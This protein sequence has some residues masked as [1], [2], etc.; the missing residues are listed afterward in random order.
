MVGEEMTGAIGHGLVALVGIGVG[1]EEDELRWMADKIVGLRI[2]DDADGRFDQSLRDVGGALLS[3]SQFTLLADVRKG[4]RPSFTRAAHPDVALPAWE[5][6]NEL[7]RAQ[8][9]EVATG[10]FAVHMSVNIMNDGPV[11]VT[12]DRSPT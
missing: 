1:D 7:V 9:V 8:G 10:R 11:T 12:L 3:I 6:F 5:R 2:F 4:T